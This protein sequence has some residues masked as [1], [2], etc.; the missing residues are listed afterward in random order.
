MDATIGAGEFKAKCLQ[1][2]D[3][4]AERRQPLI[5]SKR[6]R[7]LAKLVPIESTRSLFGA[8]AGSVTHEEDIVSPPDA[9]WDAS[10]PA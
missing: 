6:G 10:S 5:I 3:E 8:M 4:V 1:L 2:I 7:P 9:P